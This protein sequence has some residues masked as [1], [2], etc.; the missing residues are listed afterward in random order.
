MSTTSKSGGS[1][2]KCKRGCSPKNASQNN[3]NQGGFTFTMGPLVWVT[4]YGPN[5]PVADK[6]FVDINTLLKDVDGLLQYMKLTCLQNAGTSELQ[7]VKLEM[8]HTLGTKLVEL[9]DSGALTPPSAGEC[10]YLELSNIDISFETKN[11]TSPSGRPLPP[12]VD[13][14]TKFDIQVFTKPCP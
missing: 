8:M 13:A 1:C 2:K 10:Q 7:E 9:E 11:C 14:E 5:E 6:P 3:R 4:G 12:D